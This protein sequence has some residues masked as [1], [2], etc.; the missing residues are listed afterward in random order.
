MRGDQDA[1]AGDVLDAPG[2]RAEREDVPDAGLVDHLLVELA[3]TAAALLG[4]RPREEDT[5]QAAVRDGASGRDGQALCAGAAGDRTGDPVPD[6]AR[7]ELGER[8]GRV[9]A[10]EHVEDRGERG[11]GEGREGGGSADHGEEVV[12]LPGV[13]RRHGDELL[14][15]DIQGI[16]RD[17]QG[18]DGPGAHPLGDHGCLDEVAAVLREDHAGG[19]GAHLVTCAAHALEAGGHG[20]RRL[21]L[22]DEVDGAHV[23]AQFEAGGGYDCGKAACLEVLLDQGALLLGDRAVVGAGDDR[24]RA[25]GGARAAHELGR[26]V[27]LVQGFAGG[28]LVGDLVETV[29]QALGQAAGVGED[30]GGAVRLDQVGDPLL[31]VGPDRGAF[32][33]LGAVGDRGAA[34]LAEVLDGD[35]DREVELL[36]RL[37]LDD[38]HLAAGER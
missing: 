30:D 16:G 20:G 13:H 1:V 22:D 33:A 18:L 27:V 5:E 17:L 21:D 4:V 38:L 35:H 14:G 24:G 34:Q 32:R 19:D 8:V 37:R 7:A 36:A 31:H 2:T 23:D 12:D 10:G 3:D 9:A 26:G 29:A 28:P 11:F 25:L 15:E 6:H